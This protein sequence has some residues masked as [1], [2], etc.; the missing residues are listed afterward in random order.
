M[1]TDV[2]V[3][4]LGAMG[5]ALARALIRGGRRVTAWNRTGGKGESLA[6]EGVIL[7]PGAAAAVAASPVVIACVAGYE[8]TRQILGPDDVPLAGRTLVQL[9]TGTPQDAR[10]AEA[11]ARSRG[12]DYLDGAILATPS[13]VGR[14]D[15]PLFVSGAEPA[16]RRA[17]ADL[18]IIAGNLIYTGESVG[19]AAAWDLGVLSSLFGALFGFLHGAR[20]FESEGLAVGDLGTMIARI[21]PVLGEMV[22][23][24]GDAIQS[25]DFGNPQSTVE[26]CTGGFELFAKQ[27]SE[28]NINGEFPDFALGL[29]RRAIAAGYGAEEFAA[30]VKVL[31]DGPAA[32]RNV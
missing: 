30:V 11:W 25:G 23:H 7:A 1:N 8:A 13:Q 32:P 17:E 18:G 24:T 3:I 19:S 21:A 29:G 5:S 9:S 22:K 27:A 14:P 2:S 6:R 31:R 16:Y 15:T 10:E 26:V 4:G 12:A 28:A 20:V